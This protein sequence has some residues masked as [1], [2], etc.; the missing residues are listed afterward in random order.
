MKP[1]SKFEIT[2]WNI[3]GETYFLRSTANTHFQNAISLVKFW[4]WKLILLPDVQ[5]M[6]QCNPFF[7]KNMSQFP[8]CW[9]SPFPLHIPASVFPVNRLAVVCLLQTAQ[10]TASATQEVVSTALKYPVILAHIVEW[11]ME[12]PAAYVTLAMKLWAIH[13]TVQVGC[14]LFQHF[15]LDCTGWPEV[16]FHGTRSKFHSIRNIGLGL[17]L[18]F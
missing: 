10:N 18:G 12:R 8:V 16:C 11:R 17:P 13:S 1:S 4:E 9:L 5:Y 2:A 15:Y 14:F 6:Y 3:T 7:W